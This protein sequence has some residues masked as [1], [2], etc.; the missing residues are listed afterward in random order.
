M[1]HSLEVRIPLLDHKLAEWTSGLPPDLK[2]RGG[3]GKFILKR[4]MRPYLPDDLLYRRKMGFAVP[5]ARWFRGPLRE[6]VRRDLLGDELADTGILDREFARRLVDEHQS[7]VRDHSAALWTLL[8][9]AGGLRVLAS[10]THEV[11]GTPTS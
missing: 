10:T 6:V 3:E 9:F 8:A 7:G 2:L 1:A 11:A 4:A 5:L